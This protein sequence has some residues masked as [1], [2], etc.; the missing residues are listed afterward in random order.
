MSAFLSTR[1]V[2]ERG[3]TR[4]RRKFRDD[5]VATASGSDTNVAQ[6]GCENRIGQLKTFR[7]YGTVRALGIS[8]TVTDFEISVT[9]D[10]AVF[11]SHDPI[12]VGGVRFGVR[13]LDDGRAFVI[14]ALEQ[15]HDFFSLR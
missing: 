8:A 2:S 10:P 3:T 1:A 11:Q 15:I 13:Y 14:Q 7:A 6:F 4:S 12:A 5:P 9:G